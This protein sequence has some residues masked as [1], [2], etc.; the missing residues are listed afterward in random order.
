MREEEE[1]KRK[2]EEDCRLRELAAAGQRVCQV[3]GQTRIDDTNVFLTPQQNAVMV[4]TLIVLDAAPVNVAPILNK[5]KTMVAASIPRSS[6]SSW[7]GNES[8]TQTPIGSRLPPLRPTNY[9]EPESSRANSHQCHEHTWRQDQSADT[10]TGHHNQPL[11]TTG[12]A[13]LIPTIRALQ[14]T[15]S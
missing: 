1:R 5:V 9:R 7:Q 4:V 14:G 15:S 2:E 10:P 12:I 3:I 6:G 8:T 11:I 13:G